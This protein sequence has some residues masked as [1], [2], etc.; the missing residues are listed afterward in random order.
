MG[1]RGR[2]LYG[3]RDSSGG[4]PPGG[5]PLWPDLPLGSGVEGGDCG[6]SPRGGDDEGRRLA[7]S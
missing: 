6:G 7:A 1:G 2:G 3:S 5:P 4:G